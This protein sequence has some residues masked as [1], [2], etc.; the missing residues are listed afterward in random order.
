MFAARA[1]TG[2]EGE[3]QRKGGEKK[4][5]GRKGEKGELK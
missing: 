1:R 2:E 4:K 3:N 5:R